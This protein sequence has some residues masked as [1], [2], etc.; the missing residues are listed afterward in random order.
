MKALTA[1]D[2]VQV[3]FPFVETAEQRIRPAVVVTTS[4]FHECG[5][6]WCLMITSA[7]HRPWHGDVAIQDLAAAGLVKPCVVRTAKIA[8][9]PTAAARPLG[10]LDEG[11]RREVGA[12]VAKSWEGLR[13]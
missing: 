10:F 11:T 8:T 5:V 4:A 13:A 12:L 1:F 2:V 6:A 7:R 3:G 9:V